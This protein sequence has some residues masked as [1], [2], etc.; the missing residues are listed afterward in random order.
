MKENKIDWASIQ[1]EH[2][3]SQAGHQN[4]ITIDMALPAIALEADPVGVAGENSLE[5][6][7]ESQPATDP[8]GISTDQPLI[9]FDASRVKLL[10]TTTLNLKVH[11]TVKVL[12]VN[13]DED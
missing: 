7:N 13:G 4:S 10:L 5:L 1:D 6:P 8:L 9:E 3:Q 12:L 11:Q 2:T